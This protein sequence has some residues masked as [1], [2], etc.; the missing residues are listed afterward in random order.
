[1]TKKTG[2]WLDDAGLRTRAIRS[3][4]SRTPEVEHAE[5]IFTSSGFL[6]DS[7]CD[8]A[9]TFAGEVDGNVYFRGTNSTVRALMR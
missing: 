3:G 9:A 4:I 7:H 5:P 1:M 2:E 6:F 8:A